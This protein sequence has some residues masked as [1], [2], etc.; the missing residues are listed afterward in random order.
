MFNWYK[1]VGD[2][3]LQVPDFSLVLKNADRY[4]GHIHDDKN[5]EED[6]EP[7]ADHL[8]LVNSYFGTLAKSH[9]LDGVI[10]GL[11][12]DFVAAN[13]QP[14]NQKWVGDY[15]K[16]LF[17]LTAVFHDYGKVND[18]FQVERLKNK[19]FR[20]IPN[21]ALTYFHSGLGAYFYIAVHLQEIRSFAFSK[22]SEILTLNRVVLWLSYPIFRHH[23]PFLSE[24][25]AHGF[26][27]DT[28]IN[29]SQKFIDRYVFDIEPLFATEVIK[30]KFLNADLIP[31]AYEKTS[32]DFELFALIK[33][34]FSML[35]ASDYLATHEYASGQKTVDL[36]VFGDRKRMQE[37]IQNMRS[38]VPHNKQLFEDF[39]L[40]VSNRENLNEASNL[41]LNRLRTE[42][43]VELIQ[44]M[45][46]H[47]DKRL[48]YIEAPT[49]GG[50]TNLSMIAAIELLESNPEL[51]K[52]Y[53]VFPFTTLITQTYQALEDTLGLKKSELVELHSKAEFASKREAQLDGEFGDKKAD[54]IDNLFALYPVTV[55]S[56]VKFF[57][58]LKTN[59]KET[60]YLLHRLANSVVIID[61]LQ[62][63]NPDIWDKMLYFICQYAK[64]FNI[65]FVL[66]SATL[67]KIGDLEIASLKDSKFTYLLPNAKAYLQ[68]ANFAKRVKF[69]FELFDK[70]DI[71]LEELANVVIEKSLDY[72]K[73]H[74]S[75]FT[76]IEFI[77]KKSASEFYSLMQEL[78]NDFDTIFVLSGT[79]LEPRRRHIIDYLKCKENRSKNVLLITTQVVEA[80]VD[81][82][83]DLGFKNVSLIDSDE[84]L[85]GRVNRNAKKATCEVYLFRKD[86]ASKLYVKDRRYKVTRKQISRTDY[87]QILNDKDFD[88][89]YKLVMAQIDDGNRKTI[90]ENFN[91]DYLLKGIKRLNFEKIDKDFKIIN[92]QNESVYVPI[93]VPIE[94]FG[95][96][97][98]SLG[99]L[100][101]LEQF[102]VEPR[103]GQLDGR[104]VWKNAYEK[105]IYNSIDLKKRGIRFDMKQVI[106]FKTLQSIMSKFTF[107]L[108]AHA[109]VIPDLMSQGFLVEKYGYKL[110]T[111]DG[112]TAKL[113]VYS[114]EQGLNEDALKTTENYF[115]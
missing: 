6:P 4:W 10:D 86:D 11:I 31:N 29:A 56:H 101:F 8:K 96:A 21:H 62:S 81:I 84:Q 26:F 83:M 55:L 102:G 82:D 85:A 41:N 106:E 32:V 14:E 75:V 9:G 70:E 97:I 107:S 74:G 89:L 37:I 94:A 104:L 61:E 111:Q 79:I 51:T 42:M 22:K 103:E 109:K 49:G 20:S 3:I 67:P 28:E 108:F 7:L 58:V 17:V 105:L 112:L 90:V 115:L 44:T 53:Y 18:N 110:L 73:V 24:P 65:R 113:P 2:L 38:S 50:K 33:L 23:S 34:N 66:M 52:I 76:I 78:P 13:F 80:G 35:T 63:F 71:Q 54:Y 12:F 15:I 88:R 1:T 91:N 87:E 39:D 57:D 47:T 98:F 68:N 25:L 72:A 95:K 99:E 93:N 69:N 114:L 60:N 64:Y 27:S 43:A 5:P 46:Q 30:H 36:G 19:R 100:Q 77:Y 59:G 45:R 16:K 48:F 40:F 92:Q